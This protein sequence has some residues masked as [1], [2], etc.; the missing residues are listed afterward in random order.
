MIKGKE[1]VL[2]FIRAN[3]APYWTIFPYG[4]SKNYCFFKSP[5]TPSLSMTESIGKLSEVLDMLES[6]RYVVSS[7]TDPAQTK[8]LRETAFELVK[9]GVLA[10]Q[11]NQQQTA[12]QSQG[13]VQAMIDAAVDKVRNE[14]ER[15]A[16]NDKI[17]MLELKVKEGEASNLD[18]AIAGI[19]KRLDPYVDPIC[20]RVFGKPQ[21]SSVAAIGFTG[22]KNNSTKTTTNMA[23]TKEAPKTE[24]EATERTRKALEI[25]QEQDPEKVV[26]V[27]EKIA[28]IAQKDKA[29]YNMYIPILLAQ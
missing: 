15:K 8:T 28:E 18:N 5:D 1:N 11:N 12:V 26:L 19:L 24:Q 3:D 17:A 13:S 9:D 4:S 22:D 20:D 6:G 29:K 10:G 14:F 2:A 7:K 16:L 23:Q 25:W 21:S 27:I